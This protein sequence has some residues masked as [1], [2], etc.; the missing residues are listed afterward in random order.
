[1]IDGHRVRITVGAPIEGPPGFQA[2]HSIVWTSDAPRIDQFAPQTSCSTK[3]VAHRN[4]TVAAIRSSAANVY[5]GDP[6][7]LSRLGL[8]S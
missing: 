8:D 2:Q 1:M 6:D 4:E 5:D 7:W 3:S